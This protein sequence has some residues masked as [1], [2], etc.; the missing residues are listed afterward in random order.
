RGEDIIVD[1]ELYGKFK[2]IGTKKYF[3]KIK[4]KEALSYAVGEGIYPNTEAR[5]NPQFERLVR[6]AKIRTD[7]W[8]HINTA[9]KAADFFAWATAKVVIGNF[10]EHYKGI[11]QFFTAES[12]KAAG[13][14][15]QAIKA[16]YSIVIHFPTAACWS[17]DGTFVWYVA[18]ASL[19]RINVLLREHPELGIKLEGAYIDIENATDTDF[20]NDRI[21]V[22]PGR[23]VSTTG[24]EKD[25]IEIGKLEIIDS[26]GQG[27]VRLVQYENKHWSLL[28]DNKPYMIKG[29][30]Y[31]PTKIGISADKPGRETLWMH[32]DSNN[33]GR[34]DAAYDSWVDKNKN[35]KRDG[36]EEVI[37]D[38][39][40][41]KDMGLNTI[42]MYHMLSK[43]EYKKEEF[44][45]D[46]LRDLFNNYGISVIMGDFLGAYGIGSGGR[47]VTD[48]KNEEQKQM[49]KNIVK[50][51]VL[52]HKDEPYVLMWILGNENEMPLSNEGVNMSM[53]NAADVPKEY[54]QFV[55]EVIEMIHEIDPDHPVAVGNFS[56]NLLR[57]FNK[58]APA[59]DVFGINSYLGIDGFGK[60]WENINRK[61]DRPVLITEY[62][63]DAYSD[64]KGVDEDSQERYHRGNWR[65][66]VYNSA[67]NEGTGTSIGGV[68]FEWLDEWWKDTGSN[69]PSKQQVMGQ[70]ALP[71]PDGWAH[72]EWFGIAGQGQGTNSPFLRELRKAYFTYK[73]MWTEK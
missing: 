2:G 6:Q 13:E 1:Y 42:R 8:S 23:F 15:R 7:I 4:K 53:T 48:Y 19:D 35:G 49:M 36:D 60:L 47:G 9:E 10:P 59:V 33:N 38:F 65:D 52:D 66:I 26:R 29:I 17:A 55:N 39:K 54:A 69:S 11:I 3:Y 44:N 68:I 64:G 56:M 18:P 41:L 72:E 46:V 73:K 16:Y 28:V 62:G 20:K 30:T 25:K 57:Y 37:G 27:K 63:C 24:E 34:P 14:I 71:F 70:S 51:M 67:G 40:L 21:T 12:L 22:N 45:K 61:F 31:A 32:E 58:Y 50:E 43:S 5:H